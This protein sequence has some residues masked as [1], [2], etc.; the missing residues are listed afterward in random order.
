VGGKGGRRLLR[1]GFSVWLPDHRSVEGHT[2]RRY[3]QAAEEITGAANG[4]M[5]LRVEQRAYAI[6]GIMHDRAAQT[7]AELVH[8]RET[9]KGRKPNLRQV[10]RAA[11]R[12][13][14]A[15]LTLKDAT[16]RLEALAGNHQRTPTEL[17][18]E[19]HRAIEDEHGG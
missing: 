8:A 4:S 10:E 2:F 1:G 11:R 14:L 13:G 15:A 7:W 3:L 16:A 12:V 6:A 5:H 19:V 9:G 17:L 18:A